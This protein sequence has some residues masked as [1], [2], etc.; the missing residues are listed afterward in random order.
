MNLSF[1]FLEVERLKNDLYGHRDED[2]PYSFDLTYEQFG[3]RYSF[4]NGSQNKRWKRRKR[5]VE[6]VIVRL[7]MGYPGS[8]YFY[9][10]KLLRERKG[11]LSMEDLLIHPEDP[12]K[13]FST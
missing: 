3:K 4:D 6:D 9:L 5:D 10:R 12:S 2:M 1:F 7:Y 13:T 11:P 8:E